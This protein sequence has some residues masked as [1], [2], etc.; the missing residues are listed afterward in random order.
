MAKIRSIRAVNF[1]GVVGDYT[2]TFDGNNG[3]PASVMML[4]D[5]GCG[6]SI[7][8]DGIGFCLRCEMQRGKVAGRD[9]KHFVICLQT[10]TSHLSLRPS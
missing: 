9:S 10:R 6:K 1:R 4:G 2:L 3:K 5:N 7:I 8:L